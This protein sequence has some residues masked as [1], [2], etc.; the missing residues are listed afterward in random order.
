MAFAAL[1]IVVLLGVV[2]VLAGNIYFWVMFSIFH[3][4]MGF[5]L[6]VQI[7]YLG[8]WR[9]GMLHKI[10][11]HFFHKKYINNLYFRL[12]HV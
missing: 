1:A 3:V 6:S 9:L 8:R 5:Y 4:L 7:Y 12:R 11:F 2:G 10:W